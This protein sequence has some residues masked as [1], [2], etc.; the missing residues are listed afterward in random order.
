MRK[1]NRGQILIGVRNCINIVLQTHDELK[2]GALALFFYI[3]MISKNQRK[4]ILAKPRGYCFSPENINCR[5]S[6]IFT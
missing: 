3:L 2:E 1:K 4:H 5:A 6:H